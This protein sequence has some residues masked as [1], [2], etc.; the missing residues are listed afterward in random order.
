[1]AGL[2]AAALSVRGLA[3]ALVF[4]RGAL[5]RNGIGALIVGAG[6]LVYQFTRL[7]N[8]VGSFGNAM[9]LLKDLVLEVW[10]RIK[11]GA[12]AAGAAATALFFDIKADAAAGEMP[13]V[14]GLSVFTCRIRRKLAPH[15]SITRNHIGF[16]LTLAPG[17]KGGPGQRYGSGGMP[18]LP[19][20]AAQWPTP[21]AQN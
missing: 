6:E 15:A 2:A 8:G 3:T 18:P 16:M 21:A 13:H 5:I 7:V 1:V 9:A 10:D 4:L 17:V 20:Q 12:T 19:A 11:M 14:Q